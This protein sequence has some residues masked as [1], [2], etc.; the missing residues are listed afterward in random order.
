M[1]TTAHRFVPVSV[2]TEHLGD[3]QET[4]IEE[5]ASQQPNCDLQDY[6][7]HIDVRRF[8]VEEL[9]RCLRQLETSS[10]QSQP[11]DGCVDESHP[12][13][14]SSLSLSTSSVPSQPLSARPTPVTP[15]SMDP[16]LCRSLAAR[17]APIPTPGI[18]PQV[19][20]RKRKYYVI[21]VG[22]C[23]GIF[24]DDWEN[25]EPLIHQVSN[26]RH[27]SFSTHDQAVEFYLGAKKLGRVRI[28]RD[29]GDDEKYGPREEGIQ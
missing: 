13:T 14:P 19:S 1:T 26:A 16:V 11:E 12:S 7:N 3:P 10:R 25:I 8:Q 15:S 9:Q 17:S 21:L 4:V 18:T 23:T 5:P 6:V 24:Y 28:V 20:P 29:P 22:R 27:K 2:D